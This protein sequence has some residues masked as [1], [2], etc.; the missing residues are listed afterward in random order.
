M[1][2]REPDYREIKIEGSKGPWVDDEPGSQPIDILSLETPEQTETRL[3]RK[4]A[5][6]QKVSSESTS[7]HRVVIASAEVKGGIAKSRA[8]RG[9]PTVGESRQENIARAV[10]MQQEIESQDEV[11]RNVAAEIRKDHDIDITAKPG[12]FARFARNR[13]IAA[14]AQLQNLVKQHAAL[15]R[16]IALNRRALDRFMESTGLEKK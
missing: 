16:S 1:D 8:E 13:K 2:Q 7:A 9:S 5:T 10:R 14:N 15:A 3:K 11:M 4:G 6:G 12:F